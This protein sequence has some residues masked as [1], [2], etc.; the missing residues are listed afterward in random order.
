MG[1]EQ[2]VKTGDIEYSLAAQK[3]IG[4][5]ERDRL[6]SEKTKKL[7][8]NLADYYSANVFS[9]ANFAIAIEQAIVSA[10]NDAVDRCVSIKY[11][12]GGPISKLPVRLF[13]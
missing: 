8:E 5:D 3:V 10:E 2:Y 11:P 13:R 6:R 12:D 1:T 9:S 7:I 4:S